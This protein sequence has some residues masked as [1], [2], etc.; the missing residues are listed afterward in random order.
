MRII[1]Q[2]VVFLV[3]NSFAV[4]SIL[5]SRHTLSL[6]QSDECN[7]D[8]CAVNSKPDG[9]LEQKILQD[10]N[11]ASKVNKSDNSSD[12]L[13]TPMNTTDHKNHDDDVKESKIKEI[14]KL[15]WTREEAER[16]LDS[17]KN[18]IENAIYYLE[19]ED[20][21]RKKLETNVKMI[22]QLGWKKDAAFSALN[23][24][25]NNISAAINMLELEEEEINKNFQEAVTD[26]VNILACTNT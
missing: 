11:I 16:A 10:W 13:I 20:D 1:L 4:K 12:K 23:H 14:M 19:L 5:I 17:N 8:F 24:C 26:M 21:N 7:G 3:I 9:N 2:F 22:E 15:G 18:D 25:N 6:I